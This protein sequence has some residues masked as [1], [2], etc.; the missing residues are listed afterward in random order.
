M[1]ILFVN[2]TSAASGAEFALMRLVSGMRP[3]HHVAVACPARG[4]L[5]DMLD[6]AA[7]EH[8]P[9]PAF[10]AS[11]R[12]DPVQ[13]PLNLARLAAGSVALARAAKRFEADLVHANTPRAGL[14]GA[15]ANRLGG[16]PLVV[17]AHEHVPLT[18]VGRGVRSVLGRSASA[19][20]TVSQ[21]V[22]RRFNDGLA[23]PLATHVYNSFDRE[24][25]DPDR[26][27]ATQVREELGIDPGAALLGQVAQITPWKA[28]DTSIRALARLQ[29][30]GLDAH[31][32]I[33]GNIAFAGPGVR[34]DNQ[35]YLRE[36]HGL[37]TELALQDR[38][39][40]LGQR[41][42]VPGILRELD[43]S[44]LPSWDEPF[45]NVMLES[46]AM[47]TPLLVSN[48]G[49]GPELVEDGVTGRVLPPKRPEV[50]ASAARE[51]LDDPQRL[52]RMG[53][54]AREATVNFSDELHARD[55]LDVYECVLAQPKPDPAAVVAAV[56]HR[57]DGAP[58]R[59]HRGARLTRARHERRHGADS[60]RA[61]RSSG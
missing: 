19:V 27:E 1:R 44:L 60:A 33:V 47:G 17:R 13:T 15:F 28:Q 26:A 8:V 38:V 36:L 20:V 24:R 29:R 61:G 10:E 12:L 58:S 54:R 43:L 49:G 46:M 32:L 3:E 7:V 21:E 59:A 11:L 22:E 48:V 9:I 53:V 35:A 30:D 18:K 45:A 52:A 25:F 57:R 37:V 41:S 55:M 56:P 40:F 39:H 34:Y 6:E 14:M 2:H 16:P 5:A 51:L 23:R 42:D 31:L 4:P 50:W